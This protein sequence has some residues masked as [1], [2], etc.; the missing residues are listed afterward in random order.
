MK[1]VSSLLQVRD[2]DLGSH[3]WANGQYSKREFVGFMPA[4]NPANGGI[5]CWHEPHKPVSQNYSNIVNYFFG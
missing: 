1:Q 2:I 3:Y 4:G 5:T